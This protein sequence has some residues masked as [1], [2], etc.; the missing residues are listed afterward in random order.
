MEIIAFIVTLVVGIYG[1]AIL[2]QWINL[3]EGGPVLAI[4]V[5]GTFILW[6]IRHP[7]NK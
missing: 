4:C 3:P 7:K 1:T 2:G 6:A 5:M